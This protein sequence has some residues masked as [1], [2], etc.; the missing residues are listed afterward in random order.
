M[1]CINY[2]KNVLQNYIQYDIELPLVISSNIFDSDNLVIWTGDMNQICFSTLDEYNFN[3]KSS[4]HDYRISSN[5]K[6]FETTNIEL[7]QDIANVLFNYYQNGYNYEIAISSLI[8][9][10]ENNKVLKK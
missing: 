3:C 9:K 2:L 8:N 5:N 7:I 1:K 6:L 10:L 4:N